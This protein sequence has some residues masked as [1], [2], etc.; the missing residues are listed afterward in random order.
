MHFHNQRCG[1]QRAP[2]LRSLWYRR[3]RQAFRPPTLS[4]MEPYMNRSFLLRTVRICIV[5]TALGWVQSW[6]SSIDYVINNA[7]FGSGPIQTFDSSTGTLVN[8]FIPGGATDSNNGRA[9]A[10]TDTLVYYTELTG[11]FGPSDGIHVA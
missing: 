6:A 11:G 9:V 10:A 7:A 8:Q 4:W 5:V 3:N 2:E 1:N